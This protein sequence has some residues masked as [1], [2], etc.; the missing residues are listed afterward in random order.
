[1]NSRNSSL[2]ADYR[3]E[4]RRIQSYLSKRRGK[5][6]FSDF[7][8]PAIP[9]KITEGSV[10]RLKKITAKKLREKEDIYVD[11][12]TGEATYS[13]NHAELTAQY[14]KVKRRKKVKSDPRI[15]DAKRNDA[16]AKIVIQNFIS[17][18]S[19]FPNTAYNAIRNFVDSMRNSVEDGDFTLK[20]FAD[21]I[22]EAESSGDYITY[23]IAY[24]PNEL[25]DYLL[26][27]VDRISKN[28]NMKGGFEF[29]KDEIET[30]IME[31]DWADYERD[32]RY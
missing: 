17:H 15:Q 29:L 5:G 28:Q 3:R 4:R 12:E 11:R 23:E 16:L 22:S 7:Q 13:K 9:K 24:D 1:M 30:F 2:K 10:R 19:H 32:G 26:R 14:N 31:G 6:F 27:I 21:S 8:L 20:E 18:A 25:S